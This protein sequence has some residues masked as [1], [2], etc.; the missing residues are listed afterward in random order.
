M[1]G[2]DDLSQRNK[3]RGAEDWSDPRHS[4]KVE[5]TAFPKGLDMTYGGNKRIIDD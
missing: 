3:C 2:N 5:W 1:K 4:L